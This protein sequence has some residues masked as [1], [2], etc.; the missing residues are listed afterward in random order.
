MDVTVTVAS[1]STTIAIVFAGVAPLIY[2]PIANLYGRR[3]VYIA[4]TAVGIAANAGC[5]VC[6]SWGP[7]LVARAFVGIGTSV[8]NVSVLST[9]SH[10]SLT[11]ILGMGIG[12]SVVA[13]MY[14]THQRGKYMGVYI[15][16]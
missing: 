11:S 5:A 2:S 13:D 10:Q 3:P 4:S 15:V 16:L 1:Y 8:G 12:G 9:Y 6:Q 14:F 7:L